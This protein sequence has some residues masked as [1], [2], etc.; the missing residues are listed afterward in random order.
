MEIKKEILEGCVKH[1]RE[2]QH[3]LYKQCYLDLMGLCLRYTKS[4]SEA[5]EVLNSAMLKVYTKIDTY[6]Q[7]GD[8]GAWI[9]RIIVNTAL[10]YLKSEKRYS[11]YADI[12][13]TALNETDHSEAP[14][15]SEYLLNMLKSLPILQNKV[16]N[17]Y[18]IEGY[19]HKEIAN[20]LQI[21]EAN[22]KWNLFTA[23][24]TLQELVNKHYSEN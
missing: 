8:F 9:R 19:S 15:E 11:D 6:N 24:K 10:D 3:K 13:D 20:M 22:S 2:A 18:A 21:S 7:Q 23:R 5:E 1:D 17:L 16:F 4:K 14:M 12:E